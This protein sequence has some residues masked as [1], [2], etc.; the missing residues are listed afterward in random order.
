MKDLLPQAVEYFRG[1][2]RFRWRALVLAWA[3]ALGG[4][5][6]VTFIPNQYESHARVFVD[7]EGVL[8]PLLLGLAV[9]TD[10]MTDVNLMQTVLLS[11]PHLD[12]V[13]RETGLY[14]RATTPAAM[15]ALVTNLSLNI[16][17][18]GGGAQNTYSISYADRDPRAAQRVVQSLL[19]S[20]VEDTLGVKRA[21]VSSAQRF[22]EDQI[23]VYD[24]R[25]REAEERLADFKRRN[26]GMM[27]RETGDYYTRL[28]AELTAAE[29]L[30]DKM[31]QV[32]SRRDELVR[33]LQGEEPTFGLLSSSDDSGAPPSPYDIRI[34]EMRAKLDSLL[35]QYT[36][37]HPEVI[38]LRESIAQLEKERDAK[39]SAGIA[40]PT[41]ID[42][43]K[44]ALRAL[45]INP[46]YQS[47]K[48]S[49]SQTDT[50]LAELRQQLAE[51][52]ERIAQLKGRVNTIPE[53]E[54]ELARLNR[55][56]DVN[57]QQY[58]AM[59]Q[60]LESAR[61]SEQAGQSTDKVKFRIIEPAVVPRRP[62]GPN[63]PLLLTGVLLLS[64]G[65]G[66]AL[67]LLLDQLR[68]AFCSR[69][70]LRDVT[71][72]PV[73]GSITRMQQL[74]GLPWYRT[75][76]LGVGAAVAALVACYAAA[77]VIIAVVGKS[78]A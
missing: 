63:R 56:Y 14:L 16:H 34:S 46:V 25:L 40:M 57:K 74:I 21:D 73:L 52:E 76:E 15:D 18:S 19:D 68:P 9:G 29:D 45:D 26:V 62:I 7:T 39:R 60:R 58:T 66:V 44:V 2:W 1:S 42:P 54:A 33:Q 32:S 55:D 3:V 70:R 50:D 49:L 31:K 20:F 47:M 35:T 17:L 28:Q 10:V 13:A 37:K 61:I 48:I 27:P 38:S 59:V 8:K 5:V 22:L 69:A 78:V 51:K 65:A 30:R 75:A 77:L 72:L 24:A 23:R 41:Q 71:G 43:Q 12:K 11:R 64:L 53:V 6:I 4:G 67:A 36:E